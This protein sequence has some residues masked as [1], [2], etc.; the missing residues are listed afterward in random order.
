[1]LEKSVLD[2]DSVLEKQSDSQLLNSKTTPAQDKSEQ[3]WEGPQAGATP[4]TKADTLGMDDGTPQIMLVE[5]YD[6]EKEALYSNRRLGK[7][8]RQSYYEEDNS[9]Q[10]SG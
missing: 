2:E 7:E 6:V 8:P 3:P 5:N 9:Y 4:T 1:M 10:K